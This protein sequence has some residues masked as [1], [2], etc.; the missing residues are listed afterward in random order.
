MPG[1]SSFDS[2]PRRDAKLRPVREDLLGLFHFFIRTGKIEPKL[3]GS[4]S[5]FNLNGCQAVS[6]HS[7]VELL[8]SFFDPVVLET[9]HDSASTGSP[10]KAI[11]NRWVATMLL[12]VGVA[13]FLI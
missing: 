11:T 12:I 10:E 8:V 2:L 5:D 6:L 13:V 9:I 7:K 4:S 3:S 1:R